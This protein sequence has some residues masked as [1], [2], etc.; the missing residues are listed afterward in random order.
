M[1]ADKLRRVIFRDDWPPERI[2]IVKNYVVAGRGASAE[3][4]REAR[5][6]DDKPS[7]RA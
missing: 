5:K 7:T 6:I 3:K 2:E 1:T 4:I